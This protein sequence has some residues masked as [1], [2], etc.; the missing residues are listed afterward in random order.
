MQIMQYI[1]LKVKIC[2]MKGHNA[3]ETKRIVGMATRA[4]VV[5]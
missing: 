2:T 4:L 5:I 3:I 1:V